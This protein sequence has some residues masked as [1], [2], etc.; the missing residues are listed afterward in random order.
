MTKNDIIKS[1]QIPSR[2]TMGIFNLPCVGG[3]QKDAIRGF[4]YV[5]QNCKTLSKKVAKITE[6]FTMAIGYIGDWLCYCKDGDWYVL[7]D[8]EYH[9][10]H[11]SFPVDSTSKTYTEWK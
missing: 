11:E 10:L 8:E 1:Y 5:L 4:S 6:N 7:T 3:A 2:I 9:K